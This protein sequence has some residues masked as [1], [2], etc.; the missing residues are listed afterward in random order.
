METRMQ[1]RSACIIPCLNCEGTIEQI[2]HKCVQSTDSVYVIDDGSTDNSSANATKAGA[3]TIRLSKNQG[4]SNALREGVEIAVREHH[5]LLVMLDADGAHDPQDISHLLSTHIKE[6]N[7]LTLGSR[8][9][10]NKNLMKIP[11]HKWW[12]NLFARYLVNQIIESE[13]PDV[14]TGFRVLDGNFAKEIQ[15]ASGFGFMVESIFYAS[16]QKYKIGYTNVNVR[17]DARQIWLTK[18]KE[19]LDFIE[20]CS[21]WCKD[22]LLSEKLGELNEK[23]TKW[24]TLKVILQSENQVLYAH[25][26][27]DKGGYIFQLQH[28]Y[29]SDASDDYISL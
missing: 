19:F 6:N 9:H 5:Q 23:L 15:Q 21:K 29:F 11:S 7:I 18:H 8:W 25:P 14:L 12:A 1:K 27:R 22:E 26:L 3:I 20:S 2:V 10:Q 28:S 16:K 24:D 4:V 17:Y 13:L